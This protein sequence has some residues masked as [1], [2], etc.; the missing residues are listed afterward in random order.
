M[1]YLAGQA[2]VADLDSRVLT[3]VAHEYVE[4]FQVAM[5]DTLGMNHLNAL[6]QLSEDAASLLFWQQA[7]PEVCHVV[8]ETAAAG[9]LGHYVGLAQVGEL[10]NQL[11]YLRG[12][13]TRY[14]RTGLTY[15]LLS[16]MLSIFL[17]W[18][19][20]AFNSN[21]GAW[22]FM[23]PSPDN[24]VCTDVHRINEIVLVDLACEPLGL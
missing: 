22:K 23:L 19:F 20:Y 3:K 16:L 9:E 14:E 2:E 24:R 10:F 18:R 11:D 17:R 8:E 5:Y 15:A 4:V 1:S 6:G 13:L 21:M 12:I 7:Y